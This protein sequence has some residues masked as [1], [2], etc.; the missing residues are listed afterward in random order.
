MRTILLLGAVVAA[1]AAPA[2]G[3][4]GV[5]ASAT[6]TG[7]T[8]ASG[9]DIRVFT[10]TAVTHDDGTTTGEAEFLRPSSGRRSHIVLDCLQVVGN[11]ATMSGTITRSSAGEEGLRAV[12]SVEDNGEGAAAAD[13]LS[14]L[15]RGPPAPDLDCRTF[16]SFL[17]LFPIDQGNIQVR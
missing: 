17:F 9:N 6:G 12:F 5:L 10:F 1:I 3:A 2:A 13:R 16:P 4:Q 7:M 8:H 15:F 14:P 11:V